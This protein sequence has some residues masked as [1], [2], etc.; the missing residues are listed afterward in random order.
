[1]YDYLSSL[2]SSTG[3]SK[4]V[5]GRMVLEVR[6]AHTTM[7]SHLLQNL[8]NYKHYHSIIVHYLCSHFE[9]LSVQPTVMCSIE[10]T[11][12]LVIVVMNSN[13]TKFIEKNGKH[14]FT[15]TPLTVADL[16]DLH[17]QK[18]ATGTA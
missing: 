18:N 13:I 12:Q 17:F 8:V 10:R 3:I 5:S 4:P 1:M 2:S 11:S 14:P 16:I 15:G 6:E 7:H 9:T